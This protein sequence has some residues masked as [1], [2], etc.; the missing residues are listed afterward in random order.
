MH[1]LIL[2]SWY[3]NFKGDINGSFFREQALALKENGNKVGV[4]YPQIRSLRDIKGIF[5]KPYGCHVEND[6]G[7]LTLRWHSV[8]FLFK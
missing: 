3:P 4:I 6:D 1:I 5:I 7:V 8:N 2:P